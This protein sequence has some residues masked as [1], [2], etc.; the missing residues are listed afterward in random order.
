MTAQSRLVHPKEGGARG[1]LEAQEDVEIIAPRVLVDVPPVGI[2]DVVDAVGSAAVAGVGQAD[3]ASAVGGGKVKG[4]RAGRNDWICAGLRPGRM[5]VELAFSRKPPG[6]WA[7]AGR[8]IRARRGSGRREGSG[9][10]GSVCHDEAASGRRRVEV[11]P[12]AEC[13]V[14]G[15]GV[16]SGSGPARR[17]RGRNGASR[18]PVVGARVPIC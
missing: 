5:A 11:G 18:G 13:G 9:E 2:A 14:R 15:H 16:L 8:A 17:C 12:G 3:A 6:A 7:A 1:A 10:R 4:P